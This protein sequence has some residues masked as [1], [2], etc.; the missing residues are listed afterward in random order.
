METL[1]KYFKFA[2]SDINLLILM[3]ICV[4][5]MAIG[6]ISLGIIYGVEYKPGRYFYAFIIFLSAIYLVHVYVKHKYLTVIEQIG[7]GEFLIG[8][9]VIAD[10][11]VES[12]N[13]LWGKN[14]ETVYV[15]SYPI[16][17]KS[18]PIPSFS[19]DFTLTI[20][21]EGYEKVSLNI[22]GQIEMVVKDRKFDW[23]N[24]YETIPAN[25]HNKINIQEFVNQ[26]FMDKCK[27][28][29]D[30]ISPIAREFFEERI[31]EARLFQRL[32]NV[33][34]YPQDAMFSNVKSVSIYLEEAKLSATT[35]NKS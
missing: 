11:V 5:I 27:S 33:L 24:I 16:I 8:M 32:V 10:K 3:A 1:K 31:T 14:D 2:C 35:D 22:S 6:L 20:E 28:R 26:K 13:L 25:E 7:W 12:G 17:W 15:V 30:I 4:T 21:V 34:E 9:K 23:Q 19:K 18:S 29:Q